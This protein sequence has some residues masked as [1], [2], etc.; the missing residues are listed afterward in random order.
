M[1]V[2]CHFLQILQNRFYSTTSPNDKGTLFHLKQVINRTSF[3][4]IPKNNMKAAEDFLEVTLCAHVITAAKQTMKT[5]S[6]SDCKAVAKALVQQFIKISLPSTEKTSNPS[7]DRVDDC[8][9]DDGINHCTSNNID[10]SVYTYATDFLTLGLLWHGYHD[11]M[12]SG[13]GDRILIYWKFLTFIFKKEGHF[14]YAKEGFNLLAQS[15]LLSPQKIAE[16]KWCRTVNTNGRPG[17]NIPVDLHIEHLNRHLKGMMR[18]LGSNITPEAVQHASRALG[19]I[20]TVCSNFEEI[21]NISASKNYH[22]KPSFERDLHKLQEQ[23]EKGEVF[24]VKEQRHH[25]GPRFRNHKPLFSSIDWKVMINWVK[26]Q[27]VNYDS[28]NI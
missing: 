4:K 24:V 3:G 17:K 21:T 15:L 2:L 12:R 22:S 10:D 14:N 7:N 26:Q 23:L 1:I 5:L 13:D 25:H 28:Y 8:I 9:N 16:L 6:V 27:V 11:A 20:E 19:T 18:N